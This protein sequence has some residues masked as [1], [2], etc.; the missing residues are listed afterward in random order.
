MHMLR[1]DCKELA[2]GS[3]TVINRPPE[4]SHFKT[5]VHWRLFCLFEGCLEKCYV[6]TVPQE[7]YSNLQYMLELSDKLLSLNF[8][9]KL[10][11]VLIPDGRGVIAQQPKYLL[12][13]SFR[14]LSPCSYGNIL[15]HYLGAN[16]L[17]Q[18]LGYGLCQWNPQFKNSQAIY[19]ARCKTFNL[20]QK[21]LSLLI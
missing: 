18:Y 11:L 15:V 19:K 14:L 3:Y 20:K 17:F 5:W 2:H 16:Q 7:T 4:T 1:P 21:C 9:G 8:F 6:Q 12:N 10:L 13:A